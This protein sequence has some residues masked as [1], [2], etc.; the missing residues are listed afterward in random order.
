MVKVALEA[1]HLMKIAIEGSDAIFKNPYSMFLNMRVIDFINKGIEIDCDP[2]IFSAKL[3]CNEMRKHKSL[4]MVN[5]NRDLL[6]YRWF[7][8]VC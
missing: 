4:R 6:R 3:A 1:P 7:D 5:N 8:H 2:S